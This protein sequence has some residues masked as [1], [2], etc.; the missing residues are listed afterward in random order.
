MNILGYNFATNKVFIVLLSCSSNR[1]S[2]V[3][4][5]VER[6]RAVEGWRLVVKGWRLGVKG[7]KEGQLVDD[8]FLKP[9]LA[10]IYTHN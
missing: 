1:M 8:D 2:I 5:D 6:R 4:Q 3:E 10:S 9:P 7:W